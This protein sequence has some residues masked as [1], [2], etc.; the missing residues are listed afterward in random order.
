MAFAIIL[1]DLLFIRC[2]YSVQCRDRNTDETTIFTRNPIHYHVGTH[3][4]LI[5]KKHFKI[6]LKQC[7]FKIALLLKKKI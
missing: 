7:I 4:K 2:K 1:S 6:L 5:L 3:L